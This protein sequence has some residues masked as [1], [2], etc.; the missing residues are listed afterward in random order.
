MCH[1][2][3]D[4]EVTSHLISALS[5]YAG[6]PGADLEFVDVTAYGLVSA[7]NVLNDRRLYP[8]AGHGYPSQDA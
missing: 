2:C 5:A 6:T 8:P 3:A 7:M 4:L 1:A